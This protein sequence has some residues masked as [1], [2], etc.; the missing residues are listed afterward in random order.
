VWARLHVVV[1]LV[2]NHVG[3]NSTAKGKLEAPKGA[4]HFIQKL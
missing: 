2:L 4:K 1:D 3:Q